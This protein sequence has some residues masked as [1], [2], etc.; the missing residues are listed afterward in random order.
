M[1]PATLATLASTAMTAYSAYSTYEAGQA[2]ADEAKKLSQQQMYDERNRAAAQQAERRARA[3][4]SGIQSG[5]GSSMMF[6]KGA[7][8]KDDERLNWMKRTGTAR[9]DAY[10][11]QGKAGAIGQLAKIPG[12]WY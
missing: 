5:T 7:K 1:D 6:R 12:Y 3:A 10:K 9:A 2:S 11:E 4:A 8:A